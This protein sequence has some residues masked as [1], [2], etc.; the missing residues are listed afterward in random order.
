ME[1]LSL[2]ICTDA[3]RV[4][5]DRSLVSVIIA[6]ILMILLLHYAVPLLFLAY[7]EYSLF[8]PLVTAFFCLV[9]SE[10]PAYLLSFVVLDEK[11]QQVVPVLRVMPVHRG[12]FIVYRMGAV[13]LLAFLASMATLFISRIFPL[14]ITMGI[15]LAISVISPMTFLIIILHAQNKIEGVAL[16]KF[17]NA[18]WV[19]PL[20]GILSAFPGSQAFGV[21][22]TYWYFGWFYSGPPSWI[23]YGLFWLVAAP[24]AAYL[25]IRTKKMLA[26]AP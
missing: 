12:F 8:Y 2:L 17:I 13:W 20:I 23:T 4:F 22:P 26:E 14:P 5:R 18:L 1:R 24:Y 25:L 21:V 9:I 7:P 11:D 10:F 15:A 3:R 16:L 6:P 19:L